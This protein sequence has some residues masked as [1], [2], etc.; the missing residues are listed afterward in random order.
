MYLRTVLL[1]Q[2][3]TIGKANTPTGIVKIPAN[4]KVQVNNLGLE[5]DFQADRR[6]HGGLDKA[7]YQ[8]PFENYATLIEALPHL[9][10]RFSQPCLGENFSSSGMTDDTVFIGDIYQIGSAKL[11]VSQPR[12]PCWKV[13]HHVGN[14][15]MMN[16][17]I[18]LN[19]T[20]WY[21]RVLEEGEVASGDSFKLIERLQSEYSVEQVWAKWVEL[22]ENKQ[23][24]TD[25]FE[26]EGLSSEWTFDW[27]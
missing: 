7:V 27:G 12:M 23:A 3:S 26:I 14:A 2:K 9:K 24:K 21:Y 4:G 11:Q 13:N 8:Y 15:H 16:L 18:A 22:R 6:V 17:M 1:A 25:R 10:L 19:R 5:G 20:G